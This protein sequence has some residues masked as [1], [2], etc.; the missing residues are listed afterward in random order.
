MSSRPH[1]TPGSEA[2]GGHQRS[3]GPLV[4]SAARRGHDDHEAG[5]VR[6]HVVDQPVRRV[7]AP[8]P[9]TIRSTPAPSAH[10]QVA[11]PGR[12]WM[13]TGTA[14]APRAR[15]RA[16]ARVRRRRIAAA[17]GRRQVERSPR[18]D[19]RHPGQ[20]EP[21]PGERQSAAALM[22]AAARPDPSITQPMR[23]KGTPARSAVV[24]SEDH[25]GDHHGAEGEHG[26]DGR[27]EDLADGHAVLL[28]VVERLTETPGARPAA[29]MGALAD[30]AGGFPALPEAG[31]GARSPVRRRP[32]C[33]PGSVVA[34]RPGP[35]DPGVRRP[36]TGGHS[37]PTP[38][39]TAPGRTT[40]RRL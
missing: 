28:Q 12:P 13:S 32:G 21:A 35:R 7:P 29:A 33:G 1:V 31:A 25:R 8:A 19:R 4:A 37:S 36:R 23:A 2:C 26:P 9:R 15:P 27:E 10:A 40:K 3:G 11:G 34:R 17:Q 30:P 6:E 20:A 39:L 5:S 24:A 18:G 14:P 16:G 38:A 22:S